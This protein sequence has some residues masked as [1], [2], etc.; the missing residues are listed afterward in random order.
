MKDTWTTVFG[1]RP[2]EIPQEREVKSI[3]MLVFPGTGLLQKPLVKKHSDEQH[4]TAHVA[5]KVESDMKHRQMLK[6]ANE[7]PGLSIPKTNLHGSND[8]H[9][10]QQV[11]DVGTSS[12]DFGGC[13]DSTS[14]VSSVSSDAHG[15]EVQTPKYKSS[16]TTDFVDLHAHP[17]SFYQDD[18][19]AEAQ[20]QENFSIEPNTG[21]QCKVMMDDNHEVKIVNAGMVPKLHEIND[22]LL[23]NTEAKCMSPHST[24]CFLQESGANTAPRDPAIGGNRLQHNVEA[25]FTSAEIVAPMLQDYAGNNLQIPVCSVRH[26]SD[27]THHSGTEEIGKSKS[28]FSVVSYFQESSELILDGNHGVDDPV[29]T[30]EQNLVAFDESSGCS[31]S[32]V[33][34][35]TIVTVAKESLLISAE[36]DIHAVNGDA[37]PGIH[38]VKTEFAAVES[39]TYA[40]DEDSEPYAMVN[41]GRLLNIPDGKES[42]TSYAISITHDSDISSKSI[43]PTNDDSVSVSDKRFAPHDSKLLDKTIGYHN[44]SHYV[45][46]GEPYHDNHDSLKTLHLSSVSEC[47][48]S[49]GG[50][51]VKNFHETNPGPFEQ[52]PCGLGE[53]SAQHQMSVRVGEIMGAACQPN[54]LSCRD[55]S[56]ELLGKSQYTDVACSLT[57]DASI[58]ILPPT[59]TRSSEAAVDVPFEPDQVCHE[60]ANDINILKDELVP[61]STFLSG[62]LSSVHCASEL[63]T[64][65]DN[66]SDSNNEC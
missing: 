2:L 66:C 34:D 29:P 27:R 52:N 50:D 61:I 5:D 21:L 31:K 46:T 10:E 54:I 51:M 42:Q 56:S 6:V 7:S 33:F 25:H 12:P 63:V 44:L 40:N 28:S 59:L 30:C 38:E 60:A 53:N 3:N 14:K 18:P 13:I 55:K 43:C 16:E 57:P 45:A 24:P 20:S 49:N 22:A 47:V 4:R 62:G 32:G 8:D 23:Q 1:F 26:S 48:S 11:K 65:L 39:E 9:Y 19:V 35:G 15:S 36:P 58:H 41:A 17:N 64:K 37:V